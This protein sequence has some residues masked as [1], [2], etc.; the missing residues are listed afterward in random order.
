MY[1]L[2]VSLKE[3]CLMHSLEQI[4]VCMIFELIRTSYGLFLF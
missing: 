4:I 2:A 1:K 3:A